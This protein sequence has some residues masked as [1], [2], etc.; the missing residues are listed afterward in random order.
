MNYKDNNALD[1]FRRK[2]EKAKSKKEKVIL[3]VTDMTWLLNKI[4]AQQEK[5]EEYVSIIDPLAKEL[6]ELRGDYD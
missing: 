5:M 4:E 2:L 1:R 6:S 3:S